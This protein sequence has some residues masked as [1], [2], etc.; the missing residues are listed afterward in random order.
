MIIKL[1]FDQTDAPPASFTSGVEAA[2]LILEKAITNPITVTIEVGY[3]QF[4][5]DRSQI[6]SGAAEALPNLGLASSS[7]YSDVL[8][9]LSAGKASDDTNFDALLT[10]GGTSISGFNGQTT[11]P[12]SNVLLFPAQQKA[13]GLGGLAANATEI[14]GFVGF[15]EIGNLPTGLPLGSLVGVAL[16]E[17]THTLGRAPYGI[18]FDDIPDIFDLFRFDTAND[19]RLVS[20][21]FLNSPPA[22]FSVNNG[23]TIL[24][25]YGEMFDP[26]DFLNDSLTR[27]DPFDELYTPGATVQSLTQLDLTQLDVL[28]FN[29]VAAIVFWTSGISGNFAAASNWT[30]S[31]STSAAVPI[32]N[33]NV[34]ISQGGIYT[35]SS[36]GNQT[37]NSLVM[38]AGATLDIVTGVFNRQRHEFLHHVRD[39]RGQRR[40]HL[41]SRRRGRQRWHDRGDGRHDRTVR[42]DHRHRRK[43]DQFGRHAECCVRRLCRLNDSQ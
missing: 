27:N 23:G 21:N 3:G 43:R 10:S 39:H 38:A 13:L 37:I 36:F 9:A 18:P 35:V 1:I 5:T 24:A 41:G 14:D 7:S 2:A 28:G 40:R 26:G 31:G 15:S 29:T 20:G 16:H 42:N 34:L 32:F 22:Y 33:N 8:A 11:Q 30:T 12:Y 25:N 19:T 17:L 4:P 6:T